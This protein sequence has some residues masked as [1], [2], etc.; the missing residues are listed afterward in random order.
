MVKELQ[1][2]L[3]EKK[4]PQKVSGLVDKI[5]EKAAWVY[6]LVMTNPVVTAY[7]TQLLLKKLP[8]EVIPFVSESI[9]NSVNSPAIKKSN[10]SRLV[11]C[12]VIGESIHGFPGVVLKYSQLGV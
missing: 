11:V 2:E 5:K 7:L 9:R 1:G 8:V 4:D 3:V 6:N 10:Q 12:R